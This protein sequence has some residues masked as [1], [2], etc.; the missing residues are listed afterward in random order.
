[1][2][3]NKKK[4]MFSLLSVIFIV[5]ILLT[6]CSASTTPAAELNENKAEDTA[7]SPATEIKDEETIIKER[8][9]DF[10][11]YY[12]DGKYIKSV[13]QIKDQTESYFI[14]DVRPADQYTKGHL[15]G[16]VN[17]PIKEIGQRFDEI[18]QNQPVL[19]ICSTGQSAAQTAGIL[20]IAGI[21]AN[22]LSGGFKAWETAGLPIEN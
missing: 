22:S 15:P 6:G 11:A 4:I 5:T 18:P 13:D 19:V 1:M 21:E 3:L 14:I 8:I 9:V 20:N 10:Y 12:P 2:N 16:A 17:I 7:A